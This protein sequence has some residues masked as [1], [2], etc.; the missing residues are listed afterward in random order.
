[1]QL[2]QGA[3]SHSRVQNDADTRNSTDTV[4][5][6]APLTTPATASV[7][8]WPTEKTLLRINLQHAPVVRFR[9]VGTDPVNA[10]TDPST[11]S[12]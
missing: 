7:A 6:T 8:C 10:D 12:T 1:M 3:V 5:P 11:P 2:L 9:Y 4:M